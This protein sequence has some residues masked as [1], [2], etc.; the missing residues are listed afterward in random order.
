MSTSEDD[1]RI[2][3]VS[4]AR[5][6][7]IAVQGSRI[8]KAS[9]GHEAFFSPASVE[10]LLD[11]PETKTI[12]IPCGGL[13][14]AKLQEMGA[15]GRLGAIPGARDEIDKVLGGGQADQFYTAFK[16]REDL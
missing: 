8:I 6:G 16:V 4:P 14:L 15:T 12:C 13:T 1:A 3:Y 2:M 11:H 9:C 5:P 10:A 7:V